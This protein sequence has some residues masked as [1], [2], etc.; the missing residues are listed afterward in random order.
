MSVE[1]LEFVGGSR[2]V[3]F[4]NTVG[5]RRA[6]KPRDHLADYADLVA[7]SRR[8]GFLDAHAAKQAELVARHRGR[9]AEQVYRR[10]LALREALYRILL[11]SMAE[12]P[13]RPDDLELLNELLGQAMSHTRLARTVRGYQLEWKD[14]E[15]VLSQMLYP[16]VR[17]AADL[18][19][20]GDL[21]RLHECEGEACGWLFLDMSKNHSRRWCSMQDC[22]NRVKARRHYHKVRMED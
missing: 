19:A 11:S 17:S 7:W 8:A 16:I 15:E 12:K 20:S 22:G 21:V 9:L 2:A 5:D 1:S 10:A 13:A 4:V 14:D 3:D 18:L 6:D